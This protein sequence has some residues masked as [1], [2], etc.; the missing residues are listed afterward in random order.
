LTEIVF[1]TQLF[2]MGISVCQIMWVTTNFYFMVNILP[3]LNHCL[4]LVIWL[5][6]FSAQGRLVV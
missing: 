1:V 3:C 5:L 2:V 6:D 4:G